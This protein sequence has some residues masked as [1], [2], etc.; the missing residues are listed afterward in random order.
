MKRVM[1]VLGS[2]ALVCLLSILGVA[3]G[4]PMSESSGAVCQTD[5]TCEMCAGGIKGGGYPLFDWNCSLTQAPSST[6]SLTY[7]EPQEGEGTCEMEEG[8]SVQTCNSTTYEFDCGEIDAPNG[9]EKPVCDFTGCSCG[10]AG[11]ADASYVGYN[12]SY[13]CT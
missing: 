11:D 8:S 5:S 13:T 1:F 2:I 3:F 6:E 9:T 7:C 12:Y 10:G 4:D